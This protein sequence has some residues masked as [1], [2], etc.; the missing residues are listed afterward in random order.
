MVTSKT[1]A[2]SPAFG[3]PSPE[4]IG[5]IEV[6]QACNELQTANFRYQTKMR[7]LNR[8]FEVK[9]ADVRQEYLDEVRQING[10]E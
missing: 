2:K 3:V 1:L 9:A 8:Q 7:D 5:N 6:A 10:D 4:V